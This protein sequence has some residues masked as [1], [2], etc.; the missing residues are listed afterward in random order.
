MD[1][2]ACCVRIV[3][4]FGVVG[5]VWRTPEWWGWVAGRLWIYPIG[6]N[7]RTRDTPYRLT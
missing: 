6:C 3:V 4:P 2:V 1:A 7:A 5:D